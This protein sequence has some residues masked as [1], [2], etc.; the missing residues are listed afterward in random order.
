M[1]K[2]KKSSVLESG[3]GLALSARLTTRRVQL[4]A[5]LVLL[6]SPFG[7]PMAERLSQD[8]SLPPEIHKGRCDPCAAGCKAYS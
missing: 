6:L 3:G 5:Q 8:M 4:G 2:K 1:K 7:M